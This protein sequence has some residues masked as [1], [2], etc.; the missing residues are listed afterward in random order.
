MKIVAFA[1]VL[2]DGRF[3]DA[4]NLYVRFVLDND[5]GHAF[6]Y[7]GDIMAGDTCQHSLAKVVEAVGNQDKQS[8]CSR[9]GILFVS[10]ADGIQQALGIASFHN[11]NRL[12]QGAQ[13]HHETCN[14]QNNLFHS[15]SFGYKDT[16]K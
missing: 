12:G 13:R 9:I 11:D 6:P 7:E 16:I 5:A 14:K 15:V 2:E 1:T 8:F 4:L 10:L 3:A